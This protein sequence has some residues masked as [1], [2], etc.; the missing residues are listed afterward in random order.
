VSNEAACCP[1]CGTTYLIKDGCLRCNPLP[2]ARARKYTR[3][4]IESPEAHE[5][6]REL[7]RQASAVGA[8]QLSLGI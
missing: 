2:P 3:K 8:C 7:K 5:E 6:S 4:G 1:T